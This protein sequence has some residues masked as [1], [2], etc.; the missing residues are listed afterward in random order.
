MAFS[1]LPSAQSLPSDGIHIPLVPAHRLDVAI[2]GYST[3]EQDR[4]RVDGHTEHKFNNK[5]AQDTQQGGEQHASTGRS[6][7]ALV[8][9]EGIVKQI[10][11][12]EVN[13]IGVPE[14]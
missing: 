7:L 4:H 13:S 3:L 1:K 11:P 6:L 8:A 5:K 14:Y 12:L 2:A 10:F 9:A